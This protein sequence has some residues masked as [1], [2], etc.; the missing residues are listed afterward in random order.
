MIYVFEGFALFLM[1]FV[2]ITLADLLIMFIRYRV[3][4]DEWRYPIDMVKF[5]EW[6]KRQENEKKD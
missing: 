5:R 2:T 3:E 1:I 6:M 4:M